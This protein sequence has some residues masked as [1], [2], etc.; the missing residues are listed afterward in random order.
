MS[1]NR[2][3]VEQG[4]SPSVSKSVK[5]LLAFIVLTFAIGACSKDRINY[6]DADVATL[7]RKAHHFANI[8]LF[9]ALISLFAPDV[10]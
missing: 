3:A 5:T 6:F 8:V 2:Q 1:F 4:D 10:N 7:Y 9:L